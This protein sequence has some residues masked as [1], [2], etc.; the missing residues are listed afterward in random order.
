L[1]LQCLYH[2][3]CESCCACVA[4]CG[5]RRTGCC[6]LF[7]GIKFKMQ[8]FNAV[9]NQARHPTTHACRGACTAH[10]QQPMRAGACLLVVSIGRMLPALKRMPRTQAQRAHAQDCCA[11]RSM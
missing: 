3:C 4:C 8:D 7:G 11:S 2:L 1:G 6:F 5:V 9:A 10:V